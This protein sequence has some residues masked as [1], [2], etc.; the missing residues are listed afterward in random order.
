MGTHTRPNDDFLMILLAILP[1]FAAIWS[2]EK[3]ILSA[4]T[5]MGFTT[6]WLLLRCRNSRDVCLALLATISIP[7]YDQLRQPV[8]SASTLPVSNAYVAAQI[9]AYSATSTGKTW[10]Q[11][12]TLAAPENFPFCFQGI[13]DIPSNSFA[14]GERLWFFVELANNQQV[15]PFVRFKIEPG[16]PGFLP[17]EAELE[18]NQEATGVSNFEYALL[19]A[20][21]RG[22]RLSGQTMREALAPLTISGLGHILSISGLHMT[23]VAVLNF[24]LLRILCRLL[25]WSLLRR[26]YWQLHA[27]LLPWLLTLPLCLI[28][29]AFVGKPA[30][31]LRALVML[32]I[33]AVVHLMAR[34]HIGYD[35][36]L[37]LAAVLCMFFYPTQTA[38][39]SFALSISAMC[40][41][42]PLA[43]TP[44]KLIFAAG[45][46]LPWLG[47]WPL[48]ASFGYANAV[49]PL[50][51]LLGTPLFSIWVFPSAWFCFLS[52]LL[53]LEML[54]RLFMDAFSY[55]LWLLFAWANWC[56]SWSGIKTAA[57]SP[58]ILPNSFYVAWA[59]LPIALTLSIKRWRCF[60]C[61]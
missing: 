20:L 22:N 16:E 18:S 47:T 53:G 41:F 26:P 58:I 30:P 51:N 13:V 33:F 17:I 39:L 7:L 48:V 34:R 2:V 40:W 24:Q 61:K 49:G 32:L 23:L 45:L 60:R 36:I 14:Y 43:I 59:L 29:V 38:S 25:P 10:L 56:L 28:F 35:Q 5:A 27:R 37:L 50:A 46:I 12:Q 19:Q 15:C 44:Q 11:L 54:A 52:E 21:T 8:Q 55:G 31:A 9:V 6:F 4:L 1:V 42:A 57:V 3:R